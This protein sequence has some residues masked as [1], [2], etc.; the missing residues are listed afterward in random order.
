MA[1]Y[2]TGLA[3]GRVFFQSARYRY[4]QRTIRILWAHIPINFNIFEFG[5]ILKRGSGDTDPC[6]LK[7]NC[8]FKEPCWSKNI[9]FSLD[10]TLL[11]DKTPWQI[12]L[13]SYHP[14]FRYW[15][16]EKL[17]FLGIRM[18]THFEST[19][20]SGLLNITTV[21]HFLYYDMDIVINI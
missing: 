21:I 19:T 16:G 14:F 3:N 2:I 6:H 20:L 7:K 13:F 17:S 5:D 1:F 12:W 11:L 10:D 18:I 15:P 8:Q 9:L 4:L